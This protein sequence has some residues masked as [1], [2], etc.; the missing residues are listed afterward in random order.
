MIKTNYGRRAWLAGAALAAAFAVGGSQAGA[1]SPRSTSAYQPGWSTAHADSANSDYAD[2][3]GAADLTLAWKREFPGGMIN[4]GATSDGEGRVYVT[5]SAPGCRLYA[6]DR[7][8]GET[9]WCAQDLDRMAVSS[10]PLLDRDGR[11]FLADG[12]A[13]RAYDRDGKVL[14]KTPIVGAPLSAQF[15]PAGDLLFITHIG[16]V[17]VL[18][19]ADGSAVL[20]PLE[21]IPGATFDPA[22]GAMACM[23]GLPECPSANTP[24]IDARGHIY[25]TFWTPGAPNAGVRAMRL[26]KGERPSLTPLWTNDALPGGSAASPDLSPD[27]KRL[28]L[29][30]NAGGLQALDTATGKTIWRFPLGHESGGSVSSSPGGLIM[31]AGGGGGVLMAVQDRGDRAELLW[32]RDDQ[33][34]RGLP[35]QTRN[36]LAYATVSTGQGENDLIVVDAAT[37]AERDREHLPGRTMFSVGTTIDRDGTVYVPTIRGQL[38]A[39]RPAASAPK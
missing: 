21:L 17:Y 20:P 8:T 37:G 4:L 36:G 10:S 22:K 16:R 35:P 19:R 2:M 38:F 6:L 28:Y 3:Q 12:T 13:M 15:T 18:R 30:D 33:S 29:T 26:K 11:I 1:P 14:W 25:F 23:R 39:Y 24:A 5:T 27:G 9:I 34:N 31:P 7:A 32:R